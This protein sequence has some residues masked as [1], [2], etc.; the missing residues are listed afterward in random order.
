MYMLPSPCPNLTLNDKKRKN[1]MITLSIL[2]KF[3]NWANLD[4]YY[5]NKPLHQLEVQ[6]DSPHYKINS[7]SPGELNDIVYK[8]NKTLGES[9]AK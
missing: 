4:L 5:K 2:R 8:F 7:I 3:L 6:N 9:D 1:S